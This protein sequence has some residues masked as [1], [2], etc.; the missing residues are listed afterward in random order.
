MELAINH[1]QKGK[2]FC[3][4]PIIAELSENIQIQTRITVLTHQI[5]YKVL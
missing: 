5:F 2:V 4:T 3:L 1:K